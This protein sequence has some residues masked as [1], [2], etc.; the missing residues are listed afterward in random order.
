MGLVT[1]GIGLVFWTTL[2]FL[3]VLFLLKKMAWKPILSAL[4]ERE[5]SITEA[6]KAA[7]KA[8]FEMA[9][10]KSDNKKLLNQARAEREELL[11]DARETKNKI[12]VEAKETAKNEANKII[13]AAHDTIENEKKAAIAELK[14]QVARISVEIAEKILK[15]ELSDPKKQDA[16]IKTSIENFKLN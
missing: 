7:D 13:K 9:E 2:S 10:L 16:L 11:K 4:K 3:I 6:L 15:D 5:H 8:K 14:E 12:V 1:P